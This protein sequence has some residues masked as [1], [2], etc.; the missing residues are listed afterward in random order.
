MSKYNR[1]INAGKYKIA[2]RNWAEPRVAQVKDAFVGRLVDT[3]Y[4]E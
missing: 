4:L 1:I 2:N 3:S